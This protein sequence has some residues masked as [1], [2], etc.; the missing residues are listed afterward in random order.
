[1][2]EQNIDSLIEELL[3][4]A[5]EESPIETSAA[6]QT[7][8]PIGQKTQTK[9]SSESHYSTET[10]YHV[11]KVEEKT[12]KNN[13]LFIVFGVLLVVVVA[14][15]LIV[16]NNSSNV[17]YEDTVASVEEDSRLE[18]DRNLVNI[19]TPDLAFFELHG[20]VKRMTERRESYSHTYEFDQKGNFVR[21]DG[22]DPFTVDIYSYEPGE[23]TRYER[24]SQGRIVREGG[25]ESGTE[26]TWK[27]DRVSG[28]EWG[29][30]SLSGTIEYQYESSTGRISSLYNTVMDL[31]EITD[32]YYQYYTYGE[33]DDY[34]NWLERSLD[35]EGKTVRKIEYYNR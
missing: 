25:Y 35:N 16:K 7:I 12:E 23:V 2:K 13:T 30:E 15:V 17:T 14:I 24:D 33:S 21:L 1:M 29:A 6:S 20:P 9:K 10:Q 5:R 32:T 22:Y 27:S 11:T 34:G 4:G 31:G 19:T 8:E 28:Y 3:G 18:N 26:Y